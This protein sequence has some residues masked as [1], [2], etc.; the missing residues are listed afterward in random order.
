LREKSHCSSGIDISVVNK[1]EASEKSGQ[2]GDAGSDQSNTRLAD[3]FLH[4]DQD[5]IRNQ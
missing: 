3:C 1:K 5:Q 4:P 2:K